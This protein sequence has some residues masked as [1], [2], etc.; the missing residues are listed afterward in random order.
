[1]ENDHAASPLMGSGNEDRAISVV[2]A[3]KDLRGEDESPFW[4][5]FISLCSNAGLADLLDVNSEKLARWPAK[6]REHLDKL[7]SDGQESGNNDEETEM[8]PTGET[9]AFTVPNP[10]SNTDPNLGAM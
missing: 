4:E 6:I 10:A 3:G 9:G 7:E 1:M 5:D 8:V 2:R